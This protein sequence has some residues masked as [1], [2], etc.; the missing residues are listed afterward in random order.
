[1]P[2]TDELG[3]RFI[4]AFSQSVSDEVPGSHELSQGQVDPKIPGGA[5]NGALDEGMP[6]ARASDYL[7]MGSPA[8]YTSANAKTLSTAPSEEIAAGAT[9]LA[10][11]APAEASLPPQVSG[12]MEAIGLGRQGWESQSSDSG[13]ITMAP[14]PMHGRYRYQVGEA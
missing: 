11:A 4:V 2:N 1:M 5:R 6:L 13:K 7:E 12:D 8:E 9:G 14:Q 10:M 3:G